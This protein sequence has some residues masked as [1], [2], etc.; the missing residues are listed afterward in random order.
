[1][2]RLPTLLLGLGLALSLAACGGDSCESLQDDIEE[3]GREIQQDPSTALDRAGELETLRK[4]LE[5][6]ECLG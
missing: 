6:L 3:I 5:E 2:R 4:R 1:M